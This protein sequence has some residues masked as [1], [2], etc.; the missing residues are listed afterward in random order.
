MDNE[1]IIQSSS[2]GPSKHTLGLRAGHTGMKHTADDRRLEPR[3][4]C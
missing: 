1:I 2:C 4:S 3:T